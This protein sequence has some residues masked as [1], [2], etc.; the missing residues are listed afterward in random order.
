MFAHERAVR[1]RNVPMSKGSLAL[2]PQGPVL[3]LPLAALQLSKGLLDEYVSETPR[4]RFSTRWRTSAG[5]AAG[6]RS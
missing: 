2:C 6:S 5:W 3:V 1:Q 4:D